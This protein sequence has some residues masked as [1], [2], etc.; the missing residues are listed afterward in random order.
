M[1]NPEHTHGEAWKATPHRGS[2]H[3]PAQ[4]LLAERAGQYIMQR[5]VSLTRP[6]GQVAP[7][8]RGAF[9][10]LPEDFVEQFPDSLADFRYAHCP[11]SHYVGIGAFQAT[12]PLS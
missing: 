7:V 2:L 9:Y 3:R 5:H 8:P 10:L 1:E 4:A 12:L 6:A 11:L